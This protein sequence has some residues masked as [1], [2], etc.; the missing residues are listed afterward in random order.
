MKNKRASVSERG[1][2]QIRR[3]NN[4]KAPRSVAY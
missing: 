3:E 4:M 2:I 1:K